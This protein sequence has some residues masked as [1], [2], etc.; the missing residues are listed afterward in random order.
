CHWRVRRRDNPDRDL[1][2]PRGPNLRPRRVPQPV[3]ACVPEV[4]KFHKFPYVFGALGGIRTPDP[5]IR[6]LVLY[7]AELRAPQPFLT[8]STFEFHLGFARPP[9]RHVVISWQAARGIRPPR[10]SASIRAFADIPE[11]ASGWQWAWAML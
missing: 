9:A 6:S 10:P 2:R 4:R 3:E 7:P 8:N 1:T 11:R 5:Q